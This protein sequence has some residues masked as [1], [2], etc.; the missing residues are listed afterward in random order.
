[1]SRELALEDLS[2]NLCRCTGYRPILAAAQVMGQWPLVQ[3]DEITLLQKLK[4]LND[5]GRWLEAYYSYIL[6]QHLS[7][8]LSA[9]ARHP[10]AQLVAGSTDVGLWINKLHMDFAQVLDV[11]QV[12]ELK[13]VEKY[14][15]HIAIGAAA[16]L[17]DAFAALVQDRPQLHAFSTRFAGLSVRNLHSEETTS[18]SAAEPPKTIAAG[19]VTPQKTSIA[20]MATP[21]LSRNTT[22]YGMQVE[23]NLLPLLL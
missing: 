14:R 16:S 6:P 23:D 18:A 3:T 20:S 10:Q 9:R 1:M 17:A 4:Q 21:P 22:H 13:R 2:G 8:L 7:A 15:H 11:T 12:R 19:V 5:T